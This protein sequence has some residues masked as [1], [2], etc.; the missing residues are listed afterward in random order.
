MSDASLNTQAKV[1]VFASG[2][3]AGTGLALMI[4]P[5]LVT[6]LLLGVEVSG[7]GTLLGRCFGIALLGLGL[8]C[9]PTRQGADCGSPAV[10][11]M[12]TYNALIALYLAY[13]GTVGHL[14]G[15]LLWPGVVLHAVVA[16]L[17]IWT[18]REKLRSKATSK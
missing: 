11:A 1:L 12:L 18:W 7:A 2:V 17:L 4:D 5:A 6:I 15:A 10:Q 9:W 3:E 13:L 16:L 14:W 8:A